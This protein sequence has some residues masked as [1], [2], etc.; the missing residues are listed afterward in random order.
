[1]EDNLI[2]TSKE[3]LNEIE[4]L[5][6]EYEKEVNEAKKDGYLKVSTARTYLLHS[7]NFVK[8]CRGE[9]TPGGRHMRNGIR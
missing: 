4:N 7:N 8:W 5:F 1:M 6:E 3:S 9:F 2:R